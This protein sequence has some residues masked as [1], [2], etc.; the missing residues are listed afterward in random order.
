MWKST[1]IIMLTMFS[2]TMQAQE[3]RLDENSFLRSFEAFWLDSTCMDKNIYHY[4][5][6][7]TS[8]FD[9]RE[10]SNGKLVFDSIVE[11]V[12]ILEVDNNGNIL[13]VGTEALSTED[14]V[15]IDTE[16]F[17][18][19]LSTL[20]WPICQLP[21][22][23]TAGNWQILVPMVYLDLDKHT[24]LPNQHPSMLR[25]TNNSISVPLQEKLFALS[26]KYPSII[27]PPVIGRKGQYLI[28]D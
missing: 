1:V 26:Q 17:R 6:R 24:G 2:L 13:G 12:L 22:A 28:R 21:Y 23:L 20:H 19:N 11:F 15:F 9:L 25:I 8:L 18:K 5:V 27:S 4:I 3:T 10:K 7:S 16:K 14:N